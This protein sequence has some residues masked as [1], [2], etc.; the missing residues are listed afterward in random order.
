MLKNKV[1]LVTGASSGIGRAIALVW[2]REGAKVVVSD[3]NVQAGEETA[4]GLDA[5]LGVAR[6]ADDDVANGLTG[7]LVGGSC[8]GGGTGGWH[9]NSVERRETRVWESM[10]VLHE[11]CGRPFARL[12]SQAGGVAG[13]PIPHSDR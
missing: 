4:D 9:G 8:G 12:A 2:A 7:M 6:E 5:V 3:V 1:A 13:C 11:N 10:N